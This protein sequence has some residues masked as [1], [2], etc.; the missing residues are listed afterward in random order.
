MNCASALEA[1]LDAEPSELAGQG[2]TALI[3]HVATCERCRAVAHQLA[4]DTRLLAASVASTT[5]RPVRFGSAIWIHRSLVPVGLVAA[6]L[7]ALV[8]RTPDA[9]KGTTFSTPT[10][11]VR[12]SVPPP[13]AVDNATPMPAQPARPRA[14]RAYPAPIPVA[15]VR[16]NAS[17]R[18]LAPTRSDGGPAVVVDASAGQRVTV[19]RT[20]NPKVIVVWLY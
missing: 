5:V 13:R 16:I 20:S 9:P 4:G 2:T 14:A 10:V 11:V 7:L 15:A 17:P 6:L 8:P 12:D 19:M 3:A 18:P 1:L